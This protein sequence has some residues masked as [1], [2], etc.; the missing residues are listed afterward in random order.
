MQILCILWELAACLVVV[1]DNVCFAALMLSVALVY[2]RSSYG[3]GRSRESVRSREGLECHAR[4][5]PSIPASLC[6]C[7]LIPTH[8]TA[9]RV[10][11]AVEQ[12]QNIHSIL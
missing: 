4:K 7:S 9:E 3:G 1:T 12:H 2:V 10:R 8:S 6:L 5:P 11:R